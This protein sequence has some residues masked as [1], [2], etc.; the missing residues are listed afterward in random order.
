[1]GYIIGYRIDYN[2]VVVLR[3]QWHSQKTLTQVTPGLK[4]FLERDYHITCLSTECRKNKNR[5]TI[6][7]I[8]VQIRK[9][10]LNMEKELVSETGNQFQIFGPL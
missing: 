3:G 2:G 1:M 6:K 9:K 7:K 4:G 8:T 10:K 5:T